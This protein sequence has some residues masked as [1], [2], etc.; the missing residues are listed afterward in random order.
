MDISRVQETINQKYVKDVGGKKYA[1]LFLLFLFKFEMTNEKHLSS[2][3]IEYQK[4]S[5]ETFKRG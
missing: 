5:T 1:T 2:Q 3:I 4:T